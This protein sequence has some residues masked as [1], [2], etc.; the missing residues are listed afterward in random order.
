MLQ[1]QRTWIPYAKWSKS[2]IT[3]KV[4]IQDYRGWEEG[5]MESCCLMVTEFLFGVMQNFWK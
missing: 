3:L 5:E 1:H 2:D 4:K